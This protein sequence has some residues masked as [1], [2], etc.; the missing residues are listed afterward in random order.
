MCNHIWQSRKTQITKHLTCQENRKARK[1]LSY[2]EIISH[3]QKPNI[4]WWLCQTFEGMTIPT[5]TQSFDIRRG[6]WVI[7]SILWGHYYLEGKVR[8]TYGFQWSFSMKTGNRI[9]ILTLM[10]Y[11]ETTTIVFLIA[12]SVK[13]KYKYL[14]PLKNINGLCFPR[15]ICFG[16]KEYTWEKLTKAVWN[17]HMKISF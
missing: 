3:T 6:R 4:C 2:N 7:F 1:T 11:Q 5:I 12:S 8:Q 17:I 14:I 9:Y 16:C 13:L 15:V 10:I